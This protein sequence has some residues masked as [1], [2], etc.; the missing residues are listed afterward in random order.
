M[1][2][3]WRSLLVLDDAN[4]ATERWISNPYHVHQRMMMAFDGR[5]PGRVLWRREKTESGKDLLVVQAGLE[6]YWV[7]AFQDLPIVTQ[8]RQSRVALR[9]EGA[10]KY[11]FKLTAYPTKS[12]KDG[13]A[14]GERGRVVVLPE[15]D[16]LDWLHRKGSNHGFEVVKANRPKRLGV[17]RPYRKRDRSVHYKF[18]VEFEGVLRPTDTERFAESII[19]GIGRGKAYGLGL[20]LHSPK[21]E[22]AE[23]TTN[24]QRSVNHG[25]Q[26][27]VDS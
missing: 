17:V 4:P 22:N 16:W 11:L 21:Q 7:Q 18:A 23:L 9:I 19:G 20:L 24:T 15:K 25:K 12:I 2:S 1:R 27:D 10:N 5:N 14:P 3:V 26:I 6:A 13:V 8:I